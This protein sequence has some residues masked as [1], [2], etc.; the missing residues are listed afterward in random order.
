MFEKCKNKNINKVTLEKYIQLIDLW[1]VNSLL[2]EYFF[3]KIMQK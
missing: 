1:Q 2:K 3:T